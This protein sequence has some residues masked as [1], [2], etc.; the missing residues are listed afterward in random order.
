MSWSGSFSV[1]NETGQTLAIMGLSHCLATITDETTLGGEVPIVNWVN[2]T[3][4]SNDAW[5]GGGTW[6]TTGGW[7]D[8][9]VWNYQIDGVS[10]SGA[11]QCNLSSSDT[12]VLLYFTGSGLSI[13]PNV[14]SNATGSNGKYSYN[15]QGQVGFLN[16]GL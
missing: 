10:H 1:K 16:G 3:P 4:L 13:H 7:N 12:E 15:T 5:L 2:W 9:W 11:H 8:I 14:S 6:V